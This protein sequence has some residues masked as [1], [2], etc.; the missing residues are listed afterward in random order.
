[1][2]PATASASNTA[3]I[4]AELRQIAG[5][6]RETVVG[7][8]QLLPGASVDVSATAAGTGRGDLVR[9]NVLR[10][11]VPITFG[12]VTR[13]LRPGESATITIAVPEPDAVYVMD[14]VVAAAFECADGGSGVESCAGSAANG[15]PV[16]TS[17]V[18]A[19]A[20]S[21]S[22]TDRVGNTQSAS[23]P[24]AVTYA[25]VSM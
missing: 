12:G 4:V 7:S 21:V 17:S 19:S 1:G 18:G 22:A 8:Y 9:V 11:R 6:G 2:S 15:S 25:L 24:F 20:F 16:Q 14:E 23:M 5:T 13:A 3:P 10:G